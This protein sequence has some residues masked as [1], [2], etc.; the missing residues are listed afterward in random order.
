M[1]VQDIG[2]VLSNLTT[3]TLGFVPNLLAATILLIIGLVLGKVIGRV[4]YEVLDRVRLDFYVS[5]TH[6]PVVSVEGIFSAIT[7]WWIYVAFITAAVG[8]LQI[9]E[10]TQVLR[11]VLAFIPNIIGAAVILT[12]G[13]LLAEYIRGHIGASGKIYAILTGK[14]LFFFVLYVSIAIALPVLGVSATLVN[15]ILIVIIGSVGLGIAIALGLGLKDA[16][17]D[18]SRRWVKKVKV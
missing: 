3:Q 6:K 2:Y 9:A 8:V 16:V 5:E 15:S 14:I 11:S 18:I 17:S 4:V 10:L 12:V 7:R 1:A 13:Y